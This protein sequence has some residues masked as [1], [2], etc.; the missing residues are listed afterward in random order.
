[1]TL[2]PE[3]KSLTSFFPKLIPVLAFL[4]IALIVAV[5]LLWRKI[6]ILEKGGVT[7]SPAAQASP[8]EVAKIKGYAKELK[9]NTKD[10][11]TCLDTGQ[12]A[13]KVKDDETYGGTVGVSGTP[14][15]FVN[16]HLVSGALPYD[17]FKNIIEFELRG[18]NWAKPDSTVAAY[19]DPKNPLIDTKK[20]DIVLGDS[21]REGDANAKIVIVEFSDF[22]CP[23]CERFYTQTEGQLKT[24]YIDTGKVLLVFKQFPLSFHE[25]A[26]KAAEASLCANLQGKFWEMHNKLFEVSVTAQ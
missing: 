17:V 26:Q 18:G 5:G 22:Q 4:V 20:V 12:T 19:V 13:Q 25:F 7:A 9:L 2:M 24:N 10:F 6:T 16:G 21:P 23:Y 11:N 3:K 1:M 15:F 8:L 14:A